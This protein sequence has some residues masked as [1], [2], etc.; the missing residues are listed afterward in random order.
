[1]S[2]VEKNTTELTFDGAMFNVV[3]DFFEAR[4]IS[5]MEI[6]EQEIMTIWQKQKEVFKIHYCF[7]CHC[8]NSKEHKLLRICSIFYPICKV[9]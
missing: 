7:D 8:L 2:Q 3:F 4:M 9:F 1:M 5:R 6:Y